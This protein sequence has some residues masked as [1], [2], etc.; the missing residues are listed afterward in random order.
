MTLVSILWSAIALAGAAAIGQ[1]EDEQPYLPGLIAT[2]VDG[3]GKQTQ[4]L[5]D[6]I[7]FD[8]GRQIPDK[9]L[10]RTPFTALWRGRLLAQGSGEYRLHV[11]ATGEIEVR[12]ASQVAIPRQTLNESWAASKPLSLSFDHHALEVNFRQTEPTARV[13]LFWSGP[14][15][16][17][18]PIA[19]R[20]LWHQRASTIS[21]AFERGRLLAA[22]LRCTAC[23]VGSP[24]VPTVD[25]P[26]LVHLAGNLRHQWLVKWL[27]NTGSHPATADGSGEIMPT[28]VRRMPAFG[29]SRDEAES[30][31]AYLLPPQKTSPV[32][33]PRLTPPAPKPSHAATDTK[34]V[35][36]E[37][38]PPSAA[39]GERLFLTLGCLA[40]HQLGSLGES[41]LFGGGDLSRVAEKRPADFFERWLSDPA[42]INPRH[43]MPVFELSSDERKSLSL[44]LATQG[45]M[46]DDA[47]DGSTKNST[48]AA[49]VERGRK[50]VQQHRCGACHE[51][52]GGPA[53]PPRVASV[54][55]DSDADWSRSCA[56]RFGDSK[57]GLGYDLSR[58]QRHDLKGFFEENLIPSSGSGVSSSQGAG[59]RTGTQNADPRSMPRAMP[60]GATL[61]VTQNCLACHAREGFF[62]I[63]SALPAQLADKLA[64]VGQAHAELAPLLPAMTPPSLASV[65]DK[66]HDEAL[67]AAIRRSGPAY[68][69]YMLVRMPKFRLADE[70]LAALVR[71]FVASDRIPAGAE[72]EIDTDDSRRSEFAAAGSRLVSTDGFGCVS[73]H[74]IGRVVP[75]KAA[76][77]ARG[78]GL[79]QLDARI[80]P[81]WFFRFLRNPAR[82]VPR[83]EMP[84]VQL[85]VKGVLRDRVEDQVSAVWQVL[86]TPGFE[87]PEPNPVRV[88]RR[89]GIADRNE[90]PLVISDVVKIG[91]RTFIHP[92]VMGLPNRQNFLFDLSEGRLAAWWIGDAARQ[93]TKGKSWHWEPGGPLV[94]PPLANNLELSILRGGRKYVPMRRGQHV[95]ELEQYVAVEQA[96]TFTYRLYMSMPD[97]PDAE[98]ICVPVRETWL[99]G[100]TA[101]VPQRNSAV[102]YLDLELPDSSDEV[103]FQAAPLAGGRFQLSSDKRS[104]RWTEPAGG[105]I[106]L[107]SPLA[108][109]SFQA[110][111][112]VALRGNKVHLA[113]A[114]VSSAEPDRFEPAEFSTAAEAVAVEIAPGFV[115]RRLPLPPDLMPT[116][117]AWRRSSVED[118]VGELCVASLK[119]QIVAAS[120]SDADGLEDAAMVVADGLATPYGLAAHGNELHV[121]T[122]SALLGIRGNEV[123]VL[124]G[125]WGHT[126]DYHDWAVGLPR[127]ERGE[128]FVGLPCQQDE[129][130][131]A[132]A[133]FRGSVLK[134][135]PRKPTSDD[136]RHYDLQVVSTGHRFPMGMALGLGGEL[137]VTDNQGNYNPFNELNHVRPGAF[138]GFIN[139]LEK[140]DAG[141]RPPPLTE[142]A[143]DIPHPWTRSVNGICFLDTPQ[144]LREQG[145]TKLFGPLEGHLVG[146]EYDTRRLIRMTLQKVDGTFQGAAYP[147]SLEPT[148]PE[149]GFLG[150]VVCAVSPRGELYVG[151]M[152]DSGWG[153]G[154]NIG[155]VVQ[156]R[157]V[158][159]E[160]IGGI[161]EVRAVR[162]GFEIEFFREVDVAKASNAKSYTIS[163][164]RRQSTPA[165]GGPD[166][167]RR[168]EKVIGVDL[169]ADR[170][171]ATLRLAELREGFVYEIALAN[172]AADGGQFHPAEAYYTLRRRVE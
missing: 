14:Q 75:D 142:P 152:R 69:P 21:S 77:S 81:R 131:A 59:K 120:D 89:S 115:G 28:P 111:G 171:R 127:N 48:E 18:E 148:S 102:R 170:R 122:K 52:P 145:K 54:R 55:L 109:A 164:Y 40:C 78:P 29:L 6:G 26:S 8:W 104:I 58:D 160:L 74:Q 33:P 35:S 79:S 86:N 60:D 126:D 17:L 137:F 150:P 128:Y 101:Q 7:A 117:L 103:I 57:A 133:R 23:H 15:F 156:V 158:P 147:L 65:G 20:F 113:L 129:R 30:I 159:S 45:A 146:C 72:R 85:A 50:L 64:A 151:S 125:G 73:C 87:P 4:R 143:I 44:F 154:N 63:R 3:S 27:Q 36:K 22:A 34:E 46:D 98:V 49:V 53:E 70:E 134:L 140:K 118:G 92:L 84:S 141:F 1:E 169:S 76:P 95:A 139:A 105:S 124:A 136:R 165:Y 71:Y 153:A 19:P 62:G 13:A 112:T 16:S 93:R 88:L 108:D 90:R 130:S 94:L 132:A 167:D 38:E 51:L 31:A 106:L 47:A 9:R 83:M 24:E 12:L 2:Y 5:D 121:L 25:A 168:N 32:A 123:R 114:Y 138:F 68:R 39:Q 166:L 91:E 149:N 42:K 119:G 110:D 162:G 43:R 41:G 66:L 97:R 67:A 82:I 155:E 157:V 10:E 61:L 100:R 116:A 161:A 144:E 135:I 99:P 11:F 80:R 37:K 163:S 56:G 172:L 96:V 107:E